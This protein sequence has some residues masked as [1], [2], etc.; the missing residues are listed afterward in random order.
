MES[1]RARHFCPWLQHHLV[2]FALQHHLVQLALQHHLVQLAAQM[3]SVR[4][5]HFLQ[6]HANS[7]EALIDRRFPFRFL[8]R[9]LRSRLGV[10][11]ENAFSS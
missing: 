7:R 11:L 6:H 1:V 2:Q 9:F 4:V 5:C 3:E 10:I 8:L